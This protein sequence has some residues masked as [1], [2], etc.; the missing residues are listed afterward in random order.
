MFIQHAPSHE[1]GW[2][3]A[4][5]R[6]DRKLPRNAPSWGA[7]GTPGTGLAH[8]LPSCVRN[9]WSAITATKYNGRPASMRVPPNSWVPNMAKRAC[10]PRC[11]GSASGPRVRGRQRRQAP[12]VAWRKDY[13]QLAW[14]GSC[15][16]CQTGVSSEF[17]ETSAICRAPKRVILHYKL[18][19]PAGMSAMLM[20]DGRTDL[21]AA[22]LLSPGCS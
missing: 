5:R 10:T 15:L 19:H 12:R 9:N 7:T 4:G 18:L 8:R 20:N 1:S 21:P 17:Y 14:H 22:S 13:T 3:Y 2:K 16:I 11:W 6:R